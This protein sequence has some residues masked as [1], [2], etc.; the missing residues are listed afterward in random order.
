VESPQRRGRPPVVAAGEPHD[1][2]EQDAADEGGVDEDGDCHADAEHLQE[3]DLPGR[4]DGEGEREDRGG[5]RDERGAALE[6]DGDGGAVVAGAVVFLLDAREHEHLVVHGEPVGDAEHE[7]GD[8]RFERS[9]RREAEQ[10]REVPVLEY[11]DERTE[12]DRQRQCV[13]DGGF[14]R[15]DDAA[16]HDEEDHDGHQHDEREDE[17]EPVEERV[18]EVGEVGG[19]AADGDGEG[20]VDGADVGDEPVG[21]LAHGVD[22]GDGR[23]PRVGGARRGEAVGVGGGDEAAVGEASGGG[24]DLGDAGERGERGGVV[25]EVGGVGRGGEDLEGVGLLGVEPGGDPIG[26][27]AAVGGLGEGAF[28]GDA[29][30]GAE[31]RGGEEQD[32]GEGGGGPRGGGGGAARRGGGGGGGGGGAP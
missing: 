30:S 15:R 13:E 28:V 1:R 29:E 8:A 4:V 2:W 27:D 3:D 22:G 23:E 7:D 5:G 14:E 19:V 26:D 9:L 31:G 17:R 24:V 16:G 6:S 18:A 20:R 21:V 32:E 10:A 11:P 25:G 12:H